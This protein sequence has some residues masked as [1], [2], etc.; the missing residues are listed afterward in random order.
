[1]DRYQTALRSEIIAHGERLVNLQEEISSLIVRREA[2]EH[3]L[4]VYEDTMSVRRVEQNNPVVP[5]GSQTAFI[6]NAIRESGD[7]GLSTGEI[8]EKAAEA[9]QTIRRPTIRSMLYHKKKGGVLE[10]LPDGRY[11]FPQ[12][13]ANGAN[14]EK[15]GDDF[16]SE[17]SFPSGAGPGQKAGAPK[18]TGE[19]DDL[20]KTA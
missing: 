20:S 13:Q 5:V 15:D 12:S 1:M 14:T 3:A 19:V 8:Y 11:R 10:H 16:A 17:R 7:R 18:V 2:L 9:A 4:A 6:L